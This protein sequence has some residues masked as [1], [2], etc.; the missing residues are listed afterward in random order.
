MAMQEAPAGR[1]LGP[2]RGAASQ[3]PL[4]L[5]GISVMESLAAAHSAAPTTF[6]AQCLRPWDAPSPSLSACII[7]VAAAVSSPF[8]VPVMHARRTTSQAAARTP[9]LGPRSASRKGQSPRAGSSPRERAARARAAGQPV[10]LEPDARRGKLSLVH[11][12][13]STFSSPQFSR[14]QNG[15]YP[16]A[17]PSRAEFRR[18]V[19]IKARVG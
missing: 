13:P 19:W 12:D 15:A 7:P 11:L 4:D 18:F 5:G 6:A 2:D 3:Q 8:E 16:R 17:H 10:F 1:M 9:P 14:P